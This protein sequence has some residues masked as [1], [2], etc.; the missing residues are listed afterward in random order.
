VGVALLKEGL[1]SYMF[2][3]IHLKPE[4]DRVYEG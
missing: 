2:K 3:V 1:N 4:I